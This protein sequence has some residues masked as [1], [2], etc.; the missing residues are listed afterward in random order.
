MSRFFVQE[1]Y[2]MLSQLGTV[3]GRQGRGVGRE[4]LR[5]A[6]PTATR[7][8]PGPSSAPETQGNG[9]LHGGRV[10]LHPVVTAWG[11]IRPGAVEGLPEVDCHEPDEVAERELEV[12]TVI[13]RK[14]RGSA[15]ALDIVA[16]LAQSG[17]RPL[18]H[19]DQGYAVAKEA[20]GI[21]RRRWSVALSDVA[22][23]QPVVGP[24]CPSQPA[25]R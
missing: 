4:L 21:R 22:W 12:I 10:A 2:W 24:S 18:L 5:F 23:S 16:M 17:S 11:A 8:A 1:D 13:D 25:Q 9:P 14:V 6:S 20:C 3:P 7:T 15:R 19:A